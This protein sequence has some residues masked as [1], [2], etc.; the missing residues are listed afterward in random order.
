MICIMAWVALLSGIYFYSMKCAGLLRVSLIDEIIG[1]DITEMG[2]NEPVVL[3]A[4]NQFATAVKTQRDK[5]S[6]VFKTAPE[7]TK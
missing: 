1:L 6:E 2:G 3:N 7:E 4:F 5:N